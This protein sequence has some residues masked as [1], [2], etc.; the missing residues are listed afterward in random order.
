MGSSDDVIRQA[1]NFEKQTRPFINIIMRALSAQKIINDIETKPSSYVYLTY[2][3]SVIQV[4]SKYFMNDFLEDIKDDKI[5]YRRLLLQMAKDNVDVLSI[6]K[7]DC[8]GK[9]SYRRNFA[10]RVFN[11][12]LALDQSVKDHLK[13]HS[14]YDIRHTA[15]ALKQL[16]NIDMRV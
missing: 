11:A 9:I 3:M 14:Q 16:Y 15:D 8:E 6:L 1:D 2:K 12:W 4:L 5:T 7:Q 10:F 13:E